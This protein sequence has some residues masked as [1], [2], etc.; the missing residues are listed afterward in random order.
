MIKAEVHINSAL[1]AA[2]AQALAQAKGG[3]DAELEQ[4][5]QTVALVAWGSM[6]FKDKTGRLRAKIKVEKSRFQ[7][8]GWL[9]TVRAP[10][11][12]LVERGHLQ[13][14]KSKSGIVRVVGHVPGK[15][16]LHKAYNRVR[17]LVISRLKQGVAG[18]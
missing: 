8:G 10:H 12:H 18:G 17:A 4:A 9:V 1:D 14:K 13:V 2:F 15:R 11:A 3:V 7:D 16:F 5:A 6:D